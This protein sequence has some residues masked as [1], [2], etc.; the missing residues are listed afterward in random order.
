MD[1]IFVLVIIQIVFVWVVMI[2]IAI[3]REIKNRR[4]FKM[5]KEAEKAREAKNPTNR[6]PRAQQEPWLH[7]LSEAQEQALLFRTIPE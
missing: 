5:L 3:E 2:G 1:S 4:W 7:T 6:K